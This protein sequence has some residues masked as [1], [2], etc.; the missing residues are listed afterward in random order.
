MLPLHALFLR[1][2]YVSLLAQVSTLSELFLLCSQNT[3]WKQR[4]LADA[5]LEVVSSG[6][7]GHRG[8]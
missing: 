2:F 1:L 6:C 3:G 8:F 5:H 4:W 7:P